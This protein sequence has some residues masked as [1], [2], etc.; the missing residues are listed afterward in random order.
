M[1][2][3]SIIEKLQY[4]FELIG[5]SYIYI[6]FL[7][8][9]LF[10]LVM[11]IMNKINKKKFLVMFIILYISLFLAVIFGN[12]DGMNNVFDGFM[13]DLFTNIYFPSVY[14]YLF[15]LLFVDIVT[16]SS[17]FN[18][19]N[20]KIYK[21]INV[22]CFSIMQFILVII[23]DYIAD[24]NID[25]FS[26]SS[27]FTSSI[28]VALLELSVN[29]F[30][31]WLVVLIGTYLVNGISAKILAYESDKELVNNSANVN[32]PLL[33]VSL[34]NGEVTDE[35][36]NDNKV[37]DTIESPIYANEIIKDDFNLNDFIQKSDNVVKEEVTNVVKEEVT[38]VVE[39]PIDILDMI[40]NNSLPV[41]KEDTTQE[42]ENNIDTY[43]LNDYKTFN[44]MLKEIRMYNIGSIVNIDRVLE[45]R[46]LD[47][48]SNEEYN[49]FKRMLKNYSN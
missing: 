45:M 44:K 33:E 35:Y 21:I 42:V 43:T 6:L 18:I 38:N 11:F 14:V 26:K 22:I 13:N 36:I 30:I 24:N 1:K 2:Y 40:L 25:V 48:F 4:L 17:V 28:L 15:I 34:D 3:T 27:L 39:K 47:K 29:I 12:L 32:E 19:K 41:I 10:G 23:M 49:L 46:L 31:G 8:I 7:G 16:V 5:S 20:D 9:M 37:N